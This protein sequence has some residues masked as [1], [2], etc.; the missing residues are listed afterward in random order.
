MIIA[1]KNGREVE[2]KDFLVNLY[3]RNGY[4]IVTDE[5]KEEP[6]VEAPTPKKT[7]TRRKKT[8]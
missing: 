6:Q 3:K 4:E 8:Q 1:R 5:P 7:T 2:I